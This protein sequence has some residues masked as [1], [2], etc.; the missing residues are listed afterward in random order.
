MEQVIG[1]SKKDKI[2]VVDDL[3]LNRSKLQDIL[4]KEYDVL[5]AENGEEGLKL[6]AANKDQIV[7]VILDLVMP[8]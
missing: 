3:K 4:S 7:A 2:L 1:M 8:A 6:L 5:E